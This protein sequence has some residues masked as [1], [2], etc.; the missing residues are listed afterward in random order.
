[1]RFSSCT[2]FP[3]LPLSQQALADVHIHHVCCPLLCVRHLR[4]VH[5]LLVQAASQRARGRVGHA[6]TH[7]LGTDQL[8]ASRVPHGATSRRHGHRLLPRLCGNCRT[9]LF[10]SLK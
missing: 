5:V 8:L 2:F 7:D 4:H 3:F 6:Q 9:L 1:M 10:V